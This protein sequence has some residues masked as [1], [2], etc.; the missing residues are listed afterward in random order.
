[1][2]FILVAEAPEQVEL[3]GVGAMTHFMRA[4]RRQTDSPGQI[5]QIDIHERLE[6]DPVRASEL[7]TNFGEQGARG[8]IEDTLADLQKSVERLKSALTQENL[9]EISDVSAEIGF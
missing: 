3:A 9:K 5:V 4:R 1:M 7:F 6:I 8:L 2:V